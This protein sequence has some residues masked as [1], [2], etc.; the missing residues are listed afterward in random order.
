LFLLRGILF[1]I[2]FFFFFFFFQSDL[3][4]GGGGAR[5][6][7]QACHQPLCTRKLGRRAHPFTRR[8]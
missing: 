5:V 7:P 8:N 3:S 2:F 1:K 4:G 6:R